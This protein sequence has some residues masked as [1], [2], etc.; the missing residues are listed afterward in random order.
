MKTRKESASR[1]LALLT[2]FVVTLTACSNSSQPATQAPDPEPEPAAS[3]YFIRTQ[4]DFDALANRV[5]DGGDRILLQRG[6]EFAGSLSLKRSRIRATERI[7]V[8]AFGD[9]ATP[10]PVLR[11][12]AADVGVIDIRDSGG[13]TIESLELIN[14]SPQRSKRHGIY[15]TAKDS[16][17]HS[18]FTVRDCYV[19]DVSGEPGNKDNGGIIFR[20]WGDSVPTRFNNILVE[21]NEIANISGVGLRIK[22]P[23]EADASDP[24]QGSSEIGRHAFQN[25][26]VR[27]NRISNITKNALIVASSDGPLIEYNVMGPAISTEVTGNSLFIFATDSAV[28]RYNEAFGNTGPA[29]DPDRGGFDADWNSRDTVFEYNYSHDNNYAFAIMR[30]YH[31]G[32]R[33][34]NNISQNER[35]GFIYYGFPT[36]NKLTDIEVSN[37][38]F[39]STSSGMQM[40]INFGRIREPV[41][42]TLVDNIFVFAAGD[43]TWGAEPNEMLGTVFENNIVVGLLESGYDGSREDPV[44]AAPGE[45]GTDID[46]RDEDRLSGYRLCTQSPAIGAKQT[47]TEP[48]E[49]DFWGNAAESQNIGAYAGLGVD[50]ST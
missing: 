11:A 39:Y 2:A 38:T 1:M 19:H 17:T 42:T 33:I 31:D 28:V 48:V 26:V 6:T 27:G 7:T 15:V 22:S 3:D 44:L 29:E 10:R 23:W 34:R 30:R 36:E 18:G 43:G 47:S 8:T 25:V 35:Y 32:L 45:G 21:N 24:R 37:N 49:T 12:D 13:W 14:D 50:C 5:F 41:S 16:G 9:S 40:F 4:A 20:V 46:M